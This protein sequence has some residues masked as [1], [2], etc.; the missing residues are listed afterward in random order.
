M[1]RTSTLQPPSVYRPRGS[2][3]A[4][5]SGPPPKPVRREVVA[6]DDCIVSPQLPLD[7][8]D[9]VRSFRHAQ[10]FAYVPQSDHISDSASASLDHWLDN[11]MRTKSV[12]IPRWKIHSS[13]PV[14]TEFKL[15]ME[16]CMA[17]I[18][19]QFRFREFVRPC[20]I[21]RRFIMGHVLAAFDAIGEYVPKFPYSD[22]GTL[23]LKY[24]GQE[25]LW[26]LEE[27]GVA[28]IH[29]LTIMSVVFHKQ[30]DGHIPILLLAMGFGPETS[31]SAKTLLFIMR[32]LYCHATYH[33]GHASLP[34][35]VIFQTE[36]QDRIQTVLWKSERDD[37]M[38]RFCVDFSGTTGHGARECE[39]II[40]RKVAQF[41]GQ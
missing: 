9:N 27:L 5:R 28:S 3:L 7:D 14:A 6:A 23:M 37:P 22:I 34:A 26:K 17:H 11:V 36:L 35:R 15:Y 21:A 24:D 40:A 38:P 32:R 12:H 1:P 41:A 39:A 19:T 8:N 33:L 16:S 31:S 20:M 25:V 18:P 13:L 29:M 2:H 4:R 30:H 10:E